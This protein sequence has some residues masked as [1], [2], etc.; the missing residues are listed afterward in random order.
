MEYRKNQTDDEKQGT[1][2]DIEEDI[3][4]VKICEDNEYKSD[5]SKDII[6]CDYILI[7]DKLYKDNK[8]DNIE[9]I[10]GEL[11]EID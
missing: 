7:K 11:N 10:E 3:I 8:E 1:V 6:D 4:E 5:K 2:Q 9:F